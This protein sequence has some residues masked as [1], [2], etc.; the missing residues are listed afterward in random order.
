MEVSSGAGLALRLVISAPG[1]SAAS[2]GSSVSH[3]RR[4]GWEWHPAS[5]NLLL[6][7]QRLQEQ[8]LACVKL[9]SKSGVFFSMILV[10]RTM[11]KQSIIADEKAV[12]E[13]LHYGF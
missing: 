8:T 2:V 6:P 9:R 1:L 11:D 3:P 13:T 5:A 12:K 4:R 10:L 7:S